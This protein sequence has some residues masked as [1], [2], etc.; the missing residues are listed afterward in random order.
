MAPRLHIGQSFEDFSFESTIECYQRAEF[1]QFF[2][3]DFRFRVL[4]KFENEIF[5]LFSGYLLN[6]VLEIG[7]K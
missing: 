4:S 3:R 1:I 2:K 6:K 5:K 7:W